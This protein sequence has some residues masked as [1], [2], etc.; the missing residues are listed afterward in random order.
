MPKRSMRPETA[1]WFLPRGLAN[2]LPK[3]SL[4]M[5]GK[6][7]IGKKSNLMFSQSP[8][9][10]KMIIMGVPQIQAEIVPM[11]SMVDR[12]SQRNL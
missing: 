12:S 9:P 8:P 2:I 1:R 6:Y 7:P 3:V 5:N 11:S 4:T 10:T